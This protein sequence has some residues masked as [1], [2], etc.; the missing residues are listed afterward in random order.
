MPSSG[1]Q[2]VLWNPMDLKRILKLSNVHSLSHTHIRNMLQAYIIK[3]HKDIIN[4]LF[5]TYFCRGWF[6]SCQLAHT[7]VEWAFQSLQMGEYCLSWCG[8]WLFILWSS[9]RRWVWICSLSNLWNLFWFLYSIYPDFQYIRLW[10]K[11]QKRTYR[12]LINFMFSKIHEVDC[13]HKN[14]YY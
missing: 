6:D 7:I 5:V 1:T 2:N 4:N 10:R 14:A 13:V 9:E 8:R 3:L 11:Q 12:G